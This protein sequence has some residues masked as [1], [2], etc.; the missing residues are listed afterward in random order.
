MSAAIA[1]RERE[2][3]RPR[4]VGVA[5]RGARSLHRRGHEPATSGRSGVERRASEEVGRL[6]RLAATGDPDAWAELVGEFS[7]L[8]RA[9]ARAHR[10]SDADIGDVVQATWLRLFEHL[11]RITE[12][13]RVG[14][15]LT[16]TARRECLSILRG[17]QRHTLLGDDMPEGES[18]DASAD[19]ALIAAERDKVLWRCFT[20]LCGRDQAL[21]QLVLAEPKLGYDEIAAALDMPI[22]SIGPTRARALERLRRE[23]DSAGAL[24]LV[25]TD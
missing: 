25:L 23:L 7:G 24:A 15:W 12:P 2:A 3:H 9:I 16:T 6:V 13:G 17:A 4:P 14:A 20:R 21:L 19:D 10:L 8:V 18:T 22:G 11:D 5:H 1:V